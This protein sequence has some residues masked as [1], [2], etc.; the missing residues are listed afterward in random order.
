MTKRFMGAVVF[1]CALLLLLFGATT[2]F[3]STSTQAGAPSGSPPS[4]SS[5]VKYAN[6]SSNVAA[7]GVQPV[8]QPVAT[9]VWTDTAPFPTITLSPTPGT[10]PLKLKR[11][12][13]ASYPPNGKLYVMGG[14]H[15]TDGED[16]TLQWIWE[17]SPGEPG[18]GTWLRKNAL[19]DSSQP[20]SR[21]TANM[22]VAVLTDTSGVRIY[23]IGG[24]SIN[25]DSSAS[26]RS[27]DPV[28]DAITVLPT[29]DNWPAS[30]TRIPGGYAV[31]NNKLYIFGGFTSIGTGSVF[32]DTWQFDPLA[33]SGS[34]W[35]F[36]P[37]VYA[38][39]F[40]AAQSLLLAVL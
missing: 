37:Y 28:A 19:L 2:F 1:A 14:R 16:T 40:H 26:V 22:A 36:F 34:K 31:Y 18:P 4:S 5:S 21:W 6:S 30:P 12:G 27:Y 25:S 24:S 13:A 35:A 15:G 39:N 7:K 23:A 20:G 29:A 9:G 33:P 10:F 17:Y 8:A 3:F 38:T 11:A 32:T